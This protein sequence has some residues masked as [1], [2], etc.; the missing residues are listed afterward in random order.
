VFVAAVVHAPAS[1][2]LLERILASRCPMERELWCD[3]A[4]PL[5][6][7]AVWRGKNHVTNTLEITL[8]QQLCI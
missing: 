5:P 4:V 8:E 1:Y 6:M 2:Y 7:E 3:D